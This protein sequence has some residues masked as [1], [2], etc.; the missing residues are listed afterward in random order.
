MSSGE[1]P[2]QLADEYSREADRLALENE[3]LADRIDAVRTD[4]HAKQHDASVP[5][6]VPPED[7]KPRDGDCADDDE[8]ASGEKPTAGEHAADR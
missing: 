1:D 6:A 7:P 8:S 2:E 5:G 3:R 4:W